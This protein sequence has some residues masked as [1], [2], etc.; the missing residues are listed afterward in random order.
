METKFGV[1]SEIGGDLFRL[2]LAPDLSLPD[3]LEAAVDA[4]NVLGLRGLYVRDLQREP[5][6]SG[7]NVLFIR[8][9]VAP[10]PRRPDLRFVRGAIA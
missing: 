6:A 8:A 1:L 7:G 2:V 3:Q 10:C 4:A 5:I 9:N